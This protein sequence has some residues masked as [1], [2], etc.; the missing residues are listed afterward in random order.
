[1]T[2]RFAIHLLGGPDPDGSIDL[3]LFAPLAAALSDLNGRVVR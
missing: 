3:G 2:E 1:M